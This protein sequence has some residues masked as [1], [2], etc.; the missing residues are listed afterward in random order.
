MLFKILF[1]YIVYLII[2]EVIRTCK[3]KKE[4]FSHT[5]YASPTDESKILKGKLKANTIDQLLPSGEE[6]VVPAFDVTDEV[7]Y[8]IETPAVAVDVIP[9][10]D[11]SNTIDSPVNCDEIESSICNPKWSIESLSTCSLNRDSCVSKKLEELPTSNVDDLLEDAIN[12]RKNYNDNLSSIQPKEFNSENIKTSEP[13][14]IET[15][16]EERLAKRKKYDNS[17]TSTPSPIVI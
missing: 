17:M 16:L 11:T 5:D 8:S 13:T 6:N 7:D 4:T 2:I 15:A 1:L 14:I 10:Y 3:K 12:R 9:A